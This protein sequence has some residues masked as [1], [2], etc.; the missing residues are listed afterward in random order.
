M[1]RFK[2]Q[3]HF[4]YDARRVH[5]HKYDYEKSLYKSD[6]APLIVTCHKHGDFSQTPFNHLRGHGCHPCGY[7]RRTRCVE[8]FRRQANLVHADRY[9][10]RKTVYQSSAKKVIV[11]CSEHGD[12]RITASGHL[13]GE[14]CRKC[15]YEKQRL[16]TSKFVDKASKVHG[17]TYDYSKTACEK[18]TDRVSIGCKNHGSFEQVANCHLQGN[19]CPRC[20]SRVST[21]SLQWLEAMKILDDTDIQH[22]GNT[23]EYRVDGT[24]L[25]VDGFSAELRKV[26]EFLGDYFHGNPRRYSP[27]V[28]NKTVGRSMGEL[29]QATCKRQKR[30]E[31]LGYEYEDAWEDEMDAAATLLTLSDVKL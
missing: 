10:Y 19:G 23:G 11:T 1:T 12:F 18:S 27:E 9:T 6:K 14:G 30:I 3:E 13:K 16:N 28:I 4:V 29:Y 7:E 20:R 15:G 22:G 31:D 24:R 2:T 8:A 17:D 21:S 26:Y 5:G 25:H